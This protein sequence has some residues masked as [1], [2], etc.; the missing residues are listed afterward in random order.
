MSGNPFERSVW[1]GSAS[2]EGDL[3][4][5]SLNEHVLSEVRSRVRAVATDRA[6]R[7]L[8][9]LGQPG[10]G[11]SHV[12]ARLS[13]ELREEVFPVVVRDYSRPGALY[14]TLFRQI[15]W[16]L[17]RTPSKRRESLLRDLVISASAEVR[18]V[19]SLAS[20]FQAHFDTSSRPPDW[21]RGFIE[22][23]TRGLE[24]A[25]A[26]ALGGG[27]RVPFHSPTAARV[28]FSYSVLTLKRHVKRWLLGE[29]LSEEDLGTLGVRRSLDDEEGARE[30]LATLSLVGVL[31]RPLLLCLDQTEQ[32]E[33]SPE[34]SGIEAMARVISALRELP[35]ILVVFSCLK[36][37]WNLGYAR[38]LPSSYRDRIHGGGNDLVELRGPR[39]EEGVELVRRRL[40]GSLGPFRKKNL[41]EFLDRYRPSPRVLLQE[42]ARQYGA[43]LRGGEKGKIR[44]PLGGEEPTT[45][46]AG[47]PLPVVARPA[48]VDPGT[49]FSRVLVRTEA[50][51]ALDPTSLEG[52]WATLLTDLGLEA[53]GKALTQ[54]RP[55]P[56][57]RVQL[58]VAA[59]GQRVGL[60]FDALVNGR[61]FASQLKSLHDDL[62]AG[63]LDRLVYWRQQPPKPSW[64]KGCQLWA[65][66]EQDSRVLV[67]R[68]AAETLRRLQAFRALCADLQGEG[69]SHREVGRAVLGGALRECQEVQEV[70]RF[71]GAQL[72]AAPEAPPQE[73]PVSGP[74]G[75]SS[76]REI[77]SGLVREARILGWSRL[78][79]LLREISP[80]PVDEHVV[81]RGLEDLEAAGV[82]WRLRGGEERYVV[83]SR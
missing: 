40:G 82:L 11:K 33:S 4:V 6:S 20:E 27:E 62:G 23:C 25:A 73:P 3:D 79:E 70:L 24:V 36:D 34:E 28:L 69:R 39:P 38:E 37:K 60:V 67:H 31:T 29:D 68:P 14:R 43:W 63:R 65:D 51:E 22:T 83:A 12:L 48:P 53:R 32:L 47:P 49:E 1:E 45:P 21:R 9:L 26:E 42:C 52:V 30:A 75:G 59:G 58:L 55:G 46:D 81:E 54:V 74:P 77:L 35:G 5:P 13:S 64:K 19:P 56:K 76:L 71:V 16:G 41:G 61:S 10:I 78:L 18:K 7:C 8:L 15:M 2:F 66:L 50:P 57:S 17:L 44:I 80:D 72:Q